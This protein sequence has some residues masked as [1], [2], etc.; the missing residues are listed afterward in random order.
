[1]VPKGLIEPYPPFMG[2]RWEGFHAG[3]FEHHGGFGRGAIGGLPG[4]FGAGRIS[5]Y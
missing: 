5:G 3:G 4:G 2:S 1:M